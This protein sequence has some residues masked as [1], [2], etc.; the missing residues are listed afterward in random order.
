MSH[1]ILFG[2]FFSRTLSPWPCPSCQGR[3]YTYHPRARP[4]C[5]V[6]P[7][8][9]R[10]PCF[11]SFWPRRT[12][13]LSTAAQ[14]PAACPRGP[15]ASGLVSEQSGKGLKKKKKKEGWVWDGIKEAR[16]TTLC[17]T[18]PIRKMCLCWT[19]L[20]YFLTDSLSNSFL[21]A[22]APV[23][24]TQ[25]KSMFCR[26]SA[27]R[28]QG[29]E[30]RYYPF[31]LTPYQLTIRDSDAAEPQPCCLLI[32]ERVHSGYEGICHF[33]VSAFMWAVKEAYF[34]TW[35]KACS[36]LSSY[37]KVEPLSFFL[38]KLSSVISN[39]KKDLII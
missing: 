18:N 39:P 25:E 37:K 27:D 32:A 33:T 2:F 23:D 30:M 6:S 36:T 1:K 26:I 35:H 13:A 5:A 12:W 9:S 10:G 11:L 17:S 21:P 31:R 16:M 8:V 22:S 4:Y 38:V 3:W 24:C 29:G 34:M 28:T 7:S 19:S 15:P 14:H 20:Y